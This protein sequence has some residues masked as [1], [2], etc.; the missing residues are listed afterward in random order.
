MADVE[1][2]RG[3]CLDETGTPK[4]KND[5]RAAIINH[6]IIEEMMDIDDA[7]DL[8]EKTLHETGFWPESTVDEPASDDA[9]DNPST[10]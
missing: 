8:A 7:E 1:L 3:L 10:A 5:C 2:L 6:L 9:P 4:P